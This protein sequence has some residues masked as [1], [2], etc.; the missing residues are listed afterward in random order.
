[1]FAR[2]SLRPFVLGIVIAATLAGCSTAGASPSSAHSSGPSSA[3]VAASPSHAP[4]LTIRYEENAQVELIAPSGRR[5]LIDMWNEDALSKPA[6]ANDILLTTH[7]HSD[8]YL[9]DYVDSFPGEKITFEEKTIKL[10]DVS[11]VAI[12]ALHDEGQAIGSD[13]IFVIEFAGLRIGHFGDLGQDKLSDE[14]LAKIGKIDIA[15]SQLSN[16]FSSMDDRN[17]KGIN[18]MKQVKPLVFI[19]THLSLE[20]AKIAANTWKAT[21]ATEPITLTPAQLPAETTVV[22]MGNQ[23]LSYGKILNLTPSSW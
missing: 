3:S 17:Q 18:L 11:I 21:Y 8:H 19:P 12:P 1:M 7:S 4:G 6:T 20:T 10:D 9:P 14:Q 23:A 2:R 13:Y 15:F 5:I 22:F 16:S